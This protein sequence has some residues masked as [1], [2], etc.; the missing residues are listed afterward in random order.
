MGIAQHREHGFTVPFPAH[1]HAHQDPL[2]LD[3]A[4]YVAFCEARFSLALALVE[5]ADALRSCMT[6][7]SKH[8]AASAGNGEGGDEATV[9]AVAGI[10]IDVDAFEARI[11]AVHQLKVGGCRRR[12]GVGRMMG[13]GW[14][15]PVWVLPVGVVACGWICGHRLP[16]PSPLWWLGLCRAPL[17]RD[18]GHHRRLRGEG[19][20]CRPGAAD[21]RSQ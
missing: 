9:D 2:Y 1:P 6:R 8:S 21:R 17:G 14:C 3:D 16:L 7:P 13:T 19:G 15:T 5:M 18:P 4:T 10:E 12:R 20:D 11:R